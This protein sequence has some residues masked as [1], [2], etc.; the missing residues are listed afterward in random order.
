MRIGIFGGTFDPPHMGHLVLADEAYI[1]LH[2]D[3][4]LWV[5]TPDPPHKLGQQISPVQQRLELVQAAIGD[6]P[7]FEL[8]R[9]EMDRPGPHFAVDTVKLLQNQYPE[10]ELFYLIGGDSLRDLVRWNRPRELVAAVAGLGVMRRP[11]D[12][13]DLAA[14]EEML[15]GIA[16]KINFIASPLIDIASHEIR[17]RI[18]AGKACRYYLHPAVYELIRQRKYYLV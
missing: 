12:E 14:L 11:G 8:S 2:L 10:A 6:N 17:K 16:S 1:Q 9:V 18:A 4:L 15:P 13:I 5:L 7:Q 3:K